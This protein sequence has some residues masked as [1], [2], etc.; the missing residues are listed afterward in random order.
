MSLPEF[1]ENKQYEIVQINQFSK[2][3][4]LSIAKQSMIPVK[5]FKRCISPKQIKGIIHQY[6][7]DYSPEGNPLLTE[8]QLDDI[9]ED[10]LSWITGFELAKMASDGKLECYWSDDKDQ[11][12]FSRNE[13]KD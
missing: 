7:D 6:C 5:E 8:E 11:F 13:I 1:D 3:L 12:I 2:S 4:G 9:C 10:I